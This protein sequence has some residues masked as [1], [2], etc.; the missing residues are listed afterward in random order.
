MRRS[1]LYR[2]TTILLNEGLM[3]NRNVFMFCRPS[4]EKLSIGILATLASMCEAGFWPPDLKLF[5]KVVLEYI[6][7]DFGG[8]F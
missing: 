6:T 4:T 5:F 7:F 2:A 1:P 3:V 8:D